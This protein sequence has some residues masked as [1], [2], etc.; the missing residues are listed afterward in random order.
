MNHNAASASCKIVGPVATDC[1]VCIHNENKNLQS[2]QD[3]HCTY[4]VTL[5]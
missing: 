5:W 1:P 3:T 2:G 4:N